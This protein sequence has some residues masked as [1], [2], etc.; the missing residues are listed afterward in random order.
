MKAAWHVIR[1]EFVNIINSS[2]NEEIC[3]E[4]WKTSTIKPIPKIDQ[5]KKASQ[6]RPINMLPTFEKV[7]ELVIKKTVG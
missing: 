5:P 3:P 4:G 6:F 2:L 7:L 1:S